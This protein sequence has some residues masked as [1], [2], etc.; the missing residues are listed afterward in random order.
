M[1]FCG[2]GWELFWGEE[3]KF[4][5]RALARKTTLKQQETAE[6]IHPTDDKGPF[7]EVFKQEIVHLQH[8]VKGQ[9]VFF[10]GI[11]RLPNTCV[12]AFVGS[13]SPGNSV[14]KRHLIWEPTLKLQND[15]KFNLMTTLFSV[16]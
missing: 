11:A 8:L 16:Q 2:A 12:R 10:V 1:N 3:R 15:K 6:R 14:L 5:E 9:A 7:D 4:L 13:S